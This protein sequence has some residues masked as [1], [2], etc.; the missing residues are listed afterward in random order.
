MVDL[1]YDKR[2]TFEPVNI[3]ADTPPV[4]DIVAFEWEIDVFIGPVD[5]FFFGSDFSPDLFLLLTVVNFE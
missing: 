5:G 4:D 1:D 2:V 3:F